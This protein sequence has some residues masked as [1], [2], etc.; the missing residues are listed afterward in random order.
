MKPSLCI[1]SATVGDVNIAAYLYGL[2]LATTLLINN[3]KV[4]RPFNA[5]TSCYMIVFTFLFGYKLTVM[6]IEN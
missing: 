3:Y 6:D 5:D 4:S 1:T 2:L